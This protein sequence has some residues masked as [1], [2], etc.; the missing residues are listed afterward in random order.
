MIYDTKCMGMCADTATAHE[1]VKIVVIIREKR[2][3]EL[4]P[5]IQNVKSEVRH[6]TSPLSYL[7]LAPHANFWKFHHQPRP[8]FL[9]STHLTPYPHPRTH[10]EKRQWQTV[11]VQHPV[12]AETVVDSALVATVAEIVVDVV[13]DVA[14]DVAEEPR[15]TRRNGSP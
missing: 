4:S 10:N 3:L 8:H 6:V 13:A 7:A 14:V 11:A 9:C 5:P 2:S 12:E 1:T 15:A